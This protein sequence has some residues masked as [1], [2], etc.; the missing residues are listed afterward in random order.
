MCK[1]K[2]P[3]LGGMQ[4]LTRLPRLRAPRLL[5]HLHLPLVFSEK[6]RPSED[7]ERWDQPLGPLLVDCGWARSI[8]A[9]GGKVSFRLITRAPILT[10][11][12]K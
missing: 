12:V 6:K 3:A 7:Q 5:L 11:L 10:P 1:C 4:G 2:L 9:G 8:L